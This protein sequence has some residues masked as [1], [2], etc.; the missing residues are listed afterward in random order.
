[1]RARLINGD[2]ALA[3]LFGAIG[4]VWILGSLGL[5]FW[6]GFAPQSGFLPFLYGVLLTALAVALLA[7]RV[8]AA[9]EASDRQ[10]IGKPLVI[11]GALTTAVVGVEIAGFGLAVF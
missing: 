6:E 5:P 3:L 2:V 10:P 11:L 8:I 1:M 4:A 7:M 9:E